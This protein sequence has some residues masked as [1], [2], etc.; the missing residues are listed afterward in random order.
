MGRDGMGWD[1]TKQDGMG[2]DGT[3]WDRYVI[4]FLYT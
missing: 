3:G 2:W 1:K 4:P